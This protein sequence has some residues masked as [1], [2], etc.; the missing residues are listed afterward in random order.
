MSELRELLPG[1]TA[2]RPGG[3]GEN[4]DGGGAFEVG[5]P[6]YA[7]LQNERTP[8]ERPPSVLDAVFTK[9]TLAYGKRFREAYAGL[10][11]DAVRG[12]WQHELAGVSPHAVAYAL[13]HLP[14]DYPP[15]VMA[16]KALC[17][18]APAPAMR[19]TIGNDRK[20]TV[21]PERF[22]SEMA[23]LRTQMS[24][25]ILSGARSLRDKER[26]GVHLTQAQR[27]F[28]RMALRHSED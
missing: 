21:M 11:L 15:T 8:P 26:N 12:D 28:W 22:K 17:R 14:P 23:R 1:A 6:S 19:A 9:L 16:F 2:L 3:A 5:P 27:A 10:P 7:N 4:A 24:S 13:Q 20:R 18:E 25:D